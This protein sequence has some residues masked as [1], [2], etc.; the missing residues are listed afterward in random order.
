MPAP[1]RLELVPGDALGPFQ[2]GSL[3]FNV[4][5]H[6]RSHR[7]EYP[8]VQV[9][10]DDD[11]PGTSPVHLVLSRPPLHLAFDPQSQR[12]SRI[13]LD[14]SS[15]I[16]PSSGSAGSWVT[17][18]G[19][20][21]RD[22]RHEPEDVL[23]TIRRV[24][25]PTYGRA[26]ARD[27]HMLNYPGVALG[28]ASDRSR[29]NR[30]IVTALPASDT[31]PLDQ[32]WLH[33]TLP[34]SPRIAHGDLSLA[35]INIDRASRKPT[36]VLLEFHSSPSTTARDLEPVTLTIGET[37]SEDILCDLG[38]AV[39]TF[40]KEEDPMSVY[41]APSTSRSSLALNPYFLSYP[42]LGLTLMCDPSRS[43]VLVKIILHSNLPGQVNFGRTSRCRWNL[44][45]NSRDQEQTETGSVDG[46]VEFEQIRKF[47]VQ[48]TLTSSPVPKDD[49]NLNSTATTTT[50]TGSNN[51][52]KKS[53]P[54]TSGSPCPS[55]TPIALPVPP[56]LAVQDL[57]LS[58]SS[59]TA[60]HGKGYT[61]DE[62]PMILDRT[63]GDD[64]SGTGRGIEGRT[65]E[66]HGFPGIAFEV[67]TTFGSKVVET[68]WLF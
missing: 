21:L 14:S 25:G 63:V 24:L 44:T 27:D 65:T 12:L 56:H 58:P 36:S 26:A 19:K 43:N 1:T 10:W 15:A 53:K 32:A 55:P 28:L 50:T 68:L 52:K 45:A 16:T 31:V 46:Q 40:W 34:P 29:L 51:K 49:A 33:P 60:P 3:L 22:D 57:D 59:T 4:L 35:Q 66:I 17:Y 38:N 23:R 18:R 11:N 48:P 20:L 62:N 5:N 6:L 61:E 54:S 41:N 7:E 39:R 67:V 42:H 64:L 37:T 8:S 9:A 13:E 30:I 2:L 47:L